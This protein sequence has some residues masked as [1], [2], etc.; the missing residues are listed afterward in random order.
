MTN[1]GINLDKWQRDFLDT[2]GDKIMCCGRQIGKSEICAIDAAEFIINNPESKPIAMIAPTERQAFSLFTKTLNYLANNYPKFIMKGKHRPTQ[3]RI[4]LKIGKYRPEIYCLPVG[5]T[6]LGIRFL[7]IG[8]LYVDEAS[9]IPELV[10]EAIEPALLTTGGDTIVLST[11]FGVGN[12]FH[13]IF[14]NKDSA[15][16]SFTRFSKDSETVMRERKICDTWTQIQQDKALLRIDRSKKRWSKARFAQEWLGHFEEDLHRWFSDKLIENTCTLKRRGYKSRVARHYMGVD[17]A[18]M[19]EDAS[20]FAI[21]DK[22]PN[23]VHQVEQIITKKTKT[24]ETEDKILFLNKE[25][26]L[27][28]T[29]ID[30]GSG[31]LGVSVFDHLVLKPEIRKKIQ[32]INNAKR[33]IEYDAEGKPKTVKVLKN[34]LYDNLRAMMEQSKIK[35]LDDEEI[36]E[37]LMSV[38]YEYEMKEGEPTKLKIFSEYNDVVESIIRGAWCIKDKINKVRFSYI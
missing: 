16:D 14:I 21:M 17:I 13:N 11:P 37:S 27:K 33:V 38:Q 23:E 8:R 20:A 15:Y 29:Y 4:K 2:K 35:L 22:M 5:A 10:W 31:T 19:G 30:A 7:T 9:R 12:E 26:D 25:W 6:G 24:N 3:T 32:M 18:R 1:Y 36:I 28:M 34:D